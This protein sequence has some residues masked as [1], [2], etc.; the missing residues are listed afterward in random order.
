MVTTSCVCGAAFS[1]E[2]GDKEAYLHFEG[3]II[4]KVP[5]AAAACKHIANTM[6]WTLT[7]SWADLGTL[8]HSMAGQAGQA[9]CKGTDWVSDSLVACRVGEGRGAQ[10]DWRGAH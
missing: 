7:V 8:G 9:G 3:V 10:C 6:S 1:T 5:T 2:Q 4:M